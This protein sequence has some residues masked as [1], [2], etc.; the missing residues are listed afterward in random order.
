MN[1]ILF[2]ELVNPDFDF[3]DFLRNYSKEHQN[4]LNNISYIKENK[5]SNVSI[6]KKNNLKTNSENNII[7]TCGE[8]NRENKEQ[9]YDQQQKQ[10]KISI[11]INKKSH[12]FTLQKND[13]TS[14][15]GNNKN[16]RLSTLS[17]LSIDKNLEPFSM[18]E[19]IEKENFIIK[20]S[21]TN[22]LKKTITIDNNNLCNSIKSENNNNKKNNNINNNN[23]NSN[24]INNNNYSLENLLLNCL[25]NSNKS[26]SSNSENS[27]SQSIEEESIKSIK[28]QLIIIINRYC[29]F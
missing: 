10:R 17:S 29:L 15:E 18:N 26:L 12:M 9:E 5:D 13:E 16:K 4:L 8:D 23:K 22:P 27:N 2:S 6:I 28:Q 1:I 21:V 24:N 20:R 25:S 14:D 19:I 3:G 11:T 7:F